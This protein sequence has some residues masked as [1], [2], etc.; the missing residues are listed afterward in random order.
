MRLSKHACTAF[1]LI[2]CTL[3]LTSCAST[4]EGR[5][6]QFG[7]VMS[8]PAG[9]A[10]FSSFSSIG[11][12]AEDITPENE[13]YLGR[14]VA[15]AITT[16]WPVY[17]KAPETTAYL[18]AICGAIAMNSSMPFLYRNYCVAILDS[19]EINA[20]A[21]PGGH[22]FIS[23]GLIQ[24]VNSEDALAAVIA[25]EIAHI[26]LKH[27]INA[28]KASRVTSAVAQAAKAS[29]MAGLVLINDSFDHAAFSDEQME[30]ILA[31]AESFSDITLEITDKLIKSGFSKA[32]EFEADEK[33][34]HLLADAGYSPYAMVDMLEMI[35]S[36][37]DH[38]W[39]A[40]HPS[41]EDR[42]SEVTDELE[43][44]EDELTMPRITREARQA[45]TARFEANR[46]I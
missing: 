20:M 25:H 43:D 31:A 46:L 40:T 32:Q 7:K 24:A 30:Q 37:G 10:I 1:V 16:Q 13:Y 2:V 11:N 45:R 4:P 29:A 3:F 8:S 36:G 44:M 26:Q 27:S 17:Q 14:S 39:G 34:L 18:N 19:D 6:R 28:I 41:P 9:N 38:G 22:I 23:R 21:T 35:P 42:I 15:A 12:A 5:I 33:A